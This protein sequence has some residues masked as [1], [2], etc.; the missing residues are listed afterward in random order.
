MEHLHFNHGHLQSP[1]ENKEMKNWKRYLRTGAI[2]LALGIPASFATYS[3]ADTQDRMIQMMHRL[4][5]IDIKDEE[6][7]RQAKNEVYDCNSRVRCLPEEGCPT[8]DDCAK[9]YADKID[10]IN[11]HTDHA[12]ANSIFAP[13]YCGQSLKTGVGIAVSLLTEIPSSGIDKTTFMGLDLV[14]AT[15]RLERKYCL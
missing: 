3:Y 10:D 2:T 9:Q 4:N 14:L 8:Y 13:L 1:R 6:L 12:I 7:V 5:A 15:S 11:R